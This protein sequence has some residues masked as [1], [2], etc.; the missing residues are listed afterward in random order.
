MPRDKWSK[1][2]K[3]RVGEYFLTYDAPDAL[4]KMNRE[5][6][7]LRARRDRLELEIPTTMVMQEM[8]KPRDTFVLAR[9]DYRNH[10]E[11]CS[12][13]RPRVPAAHARRTLPPNRLGLARWLVDPAHPLTARV[14][15]NRYWQ[16]F[17]GTGLVKT[18][19]D[20]GS[21]GEPPVH[22][23]L[24]DWLAAE[25]VRI[26]LGRE[27]HAAADRHVGHL[28][29]VVARRRRELRR[30][31]SGEPPAGARPAL[32]PAGR[33]DPRQALA[34]SGLARRARSAAPA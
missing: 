31:G 27:G 34:V 20:F 10:G 7:E 8:P 30:A 21:Q 16:M 1:E 2:Q 28:P 13:G 25:F 23:E 18:A 19:E 32:P 29:A 12:A 22:P 9:G 6:E 3:E 24:L 17:F 33:D 11:K 4:R 14:T 15:V 5:L 26:G